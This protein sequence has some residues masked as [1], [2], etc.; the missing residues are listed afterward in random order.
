[1]V[2][3]QAEAWDPWLDWAARALSAPLV[4]VSGVMH[5]PQPAAS[6]AALREAV[7]AHDALALTALYDLVTLSGSLVL[8]LAVSR[9]ALDAHAAWRISRVD[10]T[11]QAEQWGLDQDAETLAST[12]ERAFLRAEQLLALLRGGESPA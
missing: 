2:R 7:A 5:R 11:W 1:M 9:G 3:R 8:G 6:L 12:K 4:P 10:E